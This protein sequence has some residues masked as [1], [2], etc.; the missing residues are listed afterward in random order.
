MEKRTHAKILSDRRVLW[1]YK[2]GDLFWN[3]ACVGDWHVLI[4]V[5]D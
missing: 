2:A 5:S 3:V 1:V 4:S